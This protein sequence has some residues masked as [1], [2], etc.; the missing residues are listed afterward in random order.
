VGY[1]FDKSRPYRVPHDGKHDRNG[2]REF[3]E[4]D[5]TE[6]Y[7]RDNSVGF[8]IDQFSRQCPEAIRIFCWKAMVQTNVL[9]FNIAEIVE[10]FN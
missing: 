9:A 2:A 1:T 10:R 8:L 4:V 7:H 5:G 6:G 3:F